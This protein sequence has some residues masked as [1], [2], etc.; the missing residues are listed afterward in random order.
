MSNRNFFLLY[1][2]N[3]YTAGLIIGLAGAYGLQPILAGRNKEK[4]KT[5]AQH[6]GLSYRIADLADAQRVDAMLQDLD[7]V[8]HCAGPFSQT[9]LPMQQACLR[10]GTHYL[11]ITGEIGVFEQGARLH[12][13]AVQQNIMLMSGVGFDVVPTD[14]M[15]LYL[16]E[17][18][19]GATHLQLAIA[20]VGGK[21]SHG[22]AM[23]V[24]EN[25][26]ADGMVRK[27]GQLRKVPTAHK[28]L[29]IPFTKDK[30]MLSMTIP[31]GD[32]STAYRTTGIPNIETYMATSLSAVRTAKLSNY[33]NWLIGS[34]WFKRLVQRRI[35][36]SITGP[37]EAVRQKARSFVWGKVWTDNGGSAEARLSG[38]DGYTLTAHTALNITRKVLEGDWRP[39][40]QTP[41]GLY[42][43]DLI[44]EVAGTHRED[45]SFAG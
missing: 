21:V 39:G 6:H 37:D 2:A 26:G 5:L 1:G 42:G 36:R 4:I 24:A 20:S 15:A 35:D 40:L 22:T 9:A 16:K 19:P 14:C 23:T 34:T 33:I 8:L 7:V 30:K 10:T 44:L 45:I 13:L 25:L 43:P 11:D 31:W 32:L 18:L 29:L 27:D 38:P 17:K 28:T 41:A 12:S 3:G